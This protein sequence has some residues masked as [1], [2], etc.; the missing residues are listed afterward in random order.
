MRR[1]HCLGH[2]QSRHH[3]TQSPPAE[4]A[5]SNLPLHV[6]QLSL[7][8]SSNPQQSHVVQLLQQQI[9]MFSAERGVWRE[10]SQTMRKLAQRAGKTV[11]AG[12]VGWVGERVA[13]DDGSGAVG[14]IGRVV[15]KVDLAQ[16]L[17]LMMFEFAHHLVVSC[18]LGN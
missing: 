4:R 8:A 14:S 1:R 7:P 12:V 18:R 13:T 9:L 5:D 2:S 10:E 3:Y 16:E 15:D 11:V 17:L 6:T